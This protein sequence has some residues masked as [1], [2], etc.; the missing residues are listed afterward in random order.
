MAIKR[1]TKLYDN[2][3]FDDYPFPRPSTT[4]SI[5][6]GLHLSPFRHPS[7]QYPHFRSSSTA[8]LMHILVSC[9]HILLHFPLLHHRIY[10]HWCAS[11]LAAVFPFAALTTQTIAV[12]LMIPSIHIHADDSD[13]V[14]PPRLVYIS[15]QYPHVTF[16]IK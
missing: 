16:T 2:S 11:S 3:S 8:P 5:P 13:P 4:I 6:H 9:A 14:A 15:Y 10:T 7:L 1:S 12:V